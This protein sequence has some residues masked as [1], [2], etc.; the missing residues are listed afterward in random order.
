[1][2]ESEISINAKEIK[3]G[4]EGMKS[5]FMNK[6]VQ[7]IITIVLFLIILFS[8]SAIRVSNLDNLK[9]VT[10]G[11]YSAADPDALY[12]LRL[13][14]VV[15][16]EGSLKGIDE[17]RAPGADIV[18]LKEITPYMIVGMYK[19]VKIFDSSIDF[20]LIAILSPVIFFILGLIVF[21]FL[22]YYLTK[23][24]LIALI[25][26]AFLAF[27]PAYLFRTVAGV[28]D[29]DS[30]G[31]LGIFAS[32]LIFTLGMKKHDSSRNKTLL[33][34]ALLG[35]TT[36]FSLG[37]WAGGVTFLF[38]IIP[39]TIIIHYLF[40]LEGLKEKKEKLILFNIVWIISY[41][42]FARIIGFA[43]WDIL[44]RLL[45][46][47]SMLL[48]LVLG[49]MIVDYF[50][51]RNIKKLK[52]VKENKR[53]LYSLVIAL[54]LGILFISISGK[55]I[56]SMIGDIYAKLLSPFGYGGRL[57]STVSENA[58]PYLISWI[59]QIGKHLFWLFFAGMV[60]IGADFSRRI[61]SRKHKIYFVL[62]WII[63]ISGIL[64]SRISSEHTF[65]GTNFI[66]QLFFVGGFLVF[67]IYFI[68]IYFNKRFNIDKELIVMFSWMLFM[69]V[70]S[71]AA[72]RTIFVA[73]PFACFAAG[74]FLIKIVEQSKKTKDETLKIIVW[75]ILII[76]I[77][78]SFIILFGNPLGNPVGTYQ[79]VKSQ[80]INI[81]LA[82]N[83]QWQY[84]MEWA[85]E[86]TNEEDIFIHWWDYGY[87]VQTLAD[88]KTV[89]D[90]GHASG[91]S[92]DHNMGRYVL[93]TPNPKTAL[94]YM[95][96]WE[97]SYLIIDPTDLGKYAAY[98]KIGG[99]ENYDRFSSPFT[100]VQDESQTVETSSSKKMVYQGS[101]FVDE[102]IVYE[103][104][105]LPG[106]SFDKN[107]EIS[108]KSYVIGTLIEIEE[109]SK[110]ETKIKQPQTVFYYNNQQYQIPVRYVYYGDQMIDFKSG[111]ESTLMIIP[112]LDLDSSGQVQ[113]NPLGAAIYLSPKVSKSL[114]AKLYLM[115][116]PSNEYPTV[117]LA[118]SEND[119]VITTLRQQGMDIGEFIYYGGFRGPLK[120][121]EVEYPAGTETHEEFLELTLNQ[122]GKLDR[123]FE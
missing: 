39:V 5:F 106:Y 13:S 68:W 40:N 109:N 81:G 69:L 34:G 35:L 46:P 86:N 111:I 48:I 51:E 26:S 49:F 19:L 2:S 28:L 98:S 32:L 112:K 110:G 29:H 99:D 103:N 41:V 21:F 58:Q 1:M 83:Y 117:T 102:D 31:M 89:S 90:G 79:T 20:N 14:H 97:V 24:K 62:T 121:W 93:T 59:G 18:Y 8:A 47:S 120:I 37:A 30:I 71:R 3:K 38:M 43:V 10:T 16:E 54:I 67:F 53:V 104:I 95:K 122:E 45:T 77:V 9:D 88:R 119:Y 44:N 108:I 73:T 52:F 114:F 42:M 87:L 74:Y 85:R 84:A 115:N 66:S 27:S 100:M 64:F 25:S 113:I 70:L 123:L 78:F 56:F 116:D 76:S 72:A 82:A 17:L 107:G 75:I 118:N 15:L 6:K 12:F 92:G 36:A 60:F 105:F 7:L 23:S 33:W 94:S 80:A 65:N 96:T 11:E 101:S 57:G 63:V 22:C 61:S 55:N 91:D 50:V 4:Y